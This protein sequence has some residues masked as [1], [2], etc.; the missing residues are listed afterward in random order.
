[1]SGPLLMQ[2]F[3]REPGIL[4]EQG[5]KRRVVA[6]DARVDEQGLTDPQ[7]RGTHTRN[8]TK[9]H[10]H[11]PQCFVYKRL[12]SDRTISDTRSIVS[13]SILIH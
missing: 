9:Q 11:M 5:R 6:A 7:Q 10:V 1:M 8:H 4:G 13:G 12:A 2:G 3:R